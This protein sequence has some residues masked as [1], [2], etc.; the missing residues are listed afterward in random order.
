MNINQEIWGKKDNTLLVFVG[1]TVD[2]VLD[3]DVMDWVYFSGGIIE[4]PFDRLFSTISSARSFLKLSPEESKIHAEEIRKI[5]DNLEKRRSG[6]E[7]S[8]RKIPNEAFLRVLSGIID[9]GIKG[10]EY[11]HRRKM[12][13]LEKEEYFNANAQFGRWMKIQ[14][15]PKNYGDWA[16]YRKESISK[17]FRRNGHTDE[18]YQMVR[19]TFGPVGYWVIVNFQSMFVDIEMSKK[20]GL[21]KPSLFFR[22][23][24]RLYPYFRSEIL[25]GVALRIIVPREGREFLDKLKEDI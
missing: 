4:K 11:L 19:K 16:S 2:A 22:I 13:E 3:P 8:E 25:L 6:A 14:D 7:K 5:H 24:Y 15:V 12:T 23:V 10:F 20:L 9:Y 18:F 17:E 1:S 21:K